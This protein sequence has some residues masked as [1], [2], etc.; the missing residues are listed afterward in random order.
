[1]F[2][3]KSHIELKK[4]TERTFGLFFAAIFMI[5]C[6][7]PILQGENIRLWALL[8][9][10][11]LCLLGYF[12]PK[13]FIIPN[14][15]WIKLGMLLGAIVSPIIMG[16]IFIFV[17]TPTGIIMRLIGKDILNQKIKKSTKSYWIKRRESFDS[18][19]NQF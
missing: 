6:L 15:L 10:I 8:I 4:S 11:I 19:K 17:V 3:N 14:K 13:V 18:I 1:M 5:I 9:S 2:E 12:S 16:I 7:Y